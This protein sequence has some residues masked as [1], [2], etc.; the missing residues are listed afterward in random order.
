MICAQA[1]QPPSYRS[2]DSGSDVSY[3][4]LSLLVYSLFLFPISSIFLLHTIRSISLSF[5]LS[6]PIP[7]FFHSPPS[8]PP[9]YPNPNSHSPLFDLTISFLASALSSPVFH[10]TFLLKFTFLLSDRVYQASITGSLR[11]SLSLLF[12]LPCVPRSVRSTFPLQHPTL[13]RTTIP[14]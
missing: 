7:S 1:P 6:F 5:L 12:I 3:P 8:Q 11:I 13:A 2:C 4:P 9:L 14:K 10:P